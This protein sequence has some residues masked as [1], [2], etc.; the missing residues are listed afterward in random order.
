MVG[1]YRCRN[2]GIKKQAPKKSEKQEKK[3]NTGKEKNR[4][5]DEEAE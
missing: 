5:I 2:L 4:Q 1:R 3:E